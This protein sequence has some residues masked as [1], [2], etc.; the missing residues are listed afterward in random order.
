MA[1]IP[2]TTATDRRYLATGTGGG[3]ASGG[4]PIATPAPNQSPAGGQF[5][6]L[7]AYFSANQ[8]NAEGLAGDLAAGLGT[9]AQDAVAKAGQSGS[10]YESAGG[11]GLAADAIAARDDARRDYDALGSQAGI[12]GVLEQRQPGASYTAGMKNADAAL[13]GRSG[14]VNDARGRWG[15][16][17]GALDPTY[18]P[19]APQVQPASVS[20]PVSTKPIMDRGPGQ[21]GGAFPDDEFPSRRRRRDAEVY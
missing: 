16:V 8:P 12:A 13:L 2:R 14:A 10:T 20:Q 5:A 1:Y 7:R 9:K 15:G 3:T 21:G 11:V 17:L 19:G 6:G 18:L 4:M